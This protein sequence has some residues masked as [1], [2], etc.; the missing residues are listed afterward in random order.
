MVRVGCDARSAVCSC[1]F[2]K[3]SATDQQPL[4]V[5]S[6]FAPVPP[7]KQRHLG[8]DVARAWQKP[9]RG[10]APEALGLATLSFRAIVALRFVS[11]RGL[12][13]VMVSCRK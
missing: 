8:L 9:V 10:T 4:C 11:A 1:S 2:C 3:P 12:L 13:P 5:L 7:T 6:S